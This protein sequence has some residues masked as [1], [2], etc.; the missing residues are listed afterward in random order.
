[1]TYSKSAW[2]SFAN[3]VA[4]IWRMLAKNNKYKSQKKDKQ[5]QIFVQ[6]SSS[7]IFFLTKLIGQA[8]AQYIC[9]GF[10]Y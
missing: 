10:V 5:L 7:T 9:I 4:K 8:V 2:N 3:V 6:K 1:M